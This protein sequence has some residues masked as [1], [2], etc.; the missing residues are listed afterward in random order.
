MARRHWMSE[1]AEAVRQHAYDA[2]DTIAA[3][4]VDSVP[5][6]TPPPE[7]PKL[8]LEQYLTAPP[9]MR[10]ALLQSSG[11]PFGEMISRLQ[12]E[13]VSQYGAMAQVIMPMLSLEQSE[14]Q[15]QQV[16]QED[17]SLGIQAAHEELSTM[18]GFD[19]FAR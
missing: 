7:P 18:L 11:E 6:G 14:H 2:V 10:Q 13:A 9:E 1:V 19:P 16:A 12:N 15:M 17:P 3:G 8:S 4:I 5:F